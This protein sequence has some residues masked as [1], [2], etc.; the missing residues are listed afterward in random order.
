[1]LLLATTLG[2]LAISDE[3]FLKMLASLMRIVSKYWSFLMISSQ[4]IATFLLLLQNIDLL[5]MNSISK[6][7]ITFLEFCLKIQAICVSPWLGE[8]L[9]STSVLTPTLQAK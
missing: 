8:E 3:L 6:R 4:N 1:V 5:L 2:A 9:L 7:C